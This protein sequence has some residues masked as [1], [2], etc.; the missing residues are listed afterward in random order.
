MKAL[1]VLFLLLFVV[2]SL[3]AGVVLIEYALNLI[4]FDF[5]TTVIGSISEGWNFRLIAGLAGPA[6]IILCIIITDFIFK[7]VWRPKTMSFDNPKGK[8]V[9][10]LHALEDFIKRLVHDISGVKELKPHINVS[11]KGL[12]VMNK[13]VLEADINVPDATE[14]I[15]GVIKSKLQEMLG[16]DVQINVEVHVVK[17]LSGA[18]ES[19]DKRHTVIPFRNM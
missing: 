16:T 6:I 10:T 7:K 9:V 8:I 13:V 4:S 2:V 18:H 15:Q 12:R 19:E 1:A 14:R 11:G 3:F 5:V 17:I